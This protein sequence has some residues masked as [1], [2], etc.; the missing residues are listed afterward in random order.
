MTE[1]ILNPPK[2][3]NKI[4]W[5]S[6]RLETKLICDRKYYLEYI[7]KPKPKV[8]IPYYF[9]KGK[10]L[11]RRIEKFYDEE[12]KPWRKSAEAFANSAGA[13]FSQII[14]KGEIQGQEI[15]W[16]GKNPYAI[17]EQIKN[18]CREVYDQLL[19]DGPPIIKPEY[20]FNFLLDGR[21]F[22]GFIDRILPGMITR[23]YKTTR[24]SP[25]TLDLRHTYQFTIYELA[26]CCYCHADGGFREA[27]GVT[28]SEAA[29]WGG[30][31]IFISDKVT[32]EYFKLHYYKNK[33]KNIEEKPEIL[34]T[35]RND[36][37]Y[38]ELCELID[39]QTQEVE[40]MIELNTYIPKRGNHC[41]FCSHK[42]PCEENG[43]EVHPYQNEHGQLFLFTNYIHPIRQKKSR[44]K[45]FRF[46]K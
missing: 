18:I 28:E 5:S 31:P 40:E 15:D 41:D 20:K 26:F 24:W 34:K 32:T 8:P 37:H 38:F 30:N 10:F 9:V 42:N 17:K 39:K 4:K 46:R 43:Y 12:N 23:D 1:L 7:K 22:N 13:I 11:H 44:Q 3:D 25:N 19:A 21:W 45:S 14:K 2:I 6:S 33:D 35:K 36:K 29:E 16:Q 27:A